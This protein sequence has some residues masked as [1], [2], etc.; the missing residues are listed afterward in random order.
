MLS[1]KYSFLATLHKNALRSR[2]LAEL[3]TKANAF[4]TLKTFTN[5]KKE[6][7]LRPFCK[8][9]NREIAKYDIL[10]HGLED[11]NYSYEFEGND[12][13]FREFEQETFE[14]GSFKVNVLLEKNS[15]FI[16]LT[17]EIRSHLHLLCD[18][19]LEIFEEEFESQAMHI[20][21]YGNAA[22]EMSEEMEVIPFGTAK[23]NIAHLIFEYILLQV[24]MK[25]LQP[26]F[27]TEEG[28]ADGI[29]V[30]TDPNFEKEEEIQDPR[31]AALI[32][33]K[34]ISEGNGTS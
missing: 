25:R 20:Y 7:N 16:R 10:I 13:F 5:Q 15:T 34:Q 30:Y 1:T 23:I 19:S 14:G 6:V 29:M 17:M 21:K 24:P 12:D 28:D 31:W 4:Y 3:R 22:E 2:E 8:S 18:R 32:N 11:K 33:I 26:K 27:R 9:V